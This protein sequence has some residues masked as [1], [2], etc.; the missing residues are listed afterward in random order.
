MSIEHKN[1]CSQAGILQAL[2]LIPLMAFVKVN[3]LI[4]FEDD[5]DIHTESF[6]EFPLRRKSAA[7]KC[8]YFC[9]YV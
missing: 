7:E 2:F 6:C 4:P 3:K 8:K 9:F 1:Y 5:E